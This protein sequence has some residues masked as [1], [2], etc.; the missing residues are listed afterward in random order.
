MTNKR[1]NAGKRPPQIV[2]ASAPKTQDYFTP[3]ALK[4]QALPLTKEQLLLLVFLDDEPGGLSTDF[5]S[6]Y[7]G[8][9]VNKIVVSLR[10]LGYVIPCEVKNHIS[11]PFPKW[12]YTL[13]SCPRPPWW[14]NP[15]PTGKES[16][17][18]P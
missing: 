13:V 15:A 4:P 18:K 17:G 8:P 6:G 3:L 1:K 11:W 9:D 7:F 16:G 10:R 2:L 5:L 14:S 12:V